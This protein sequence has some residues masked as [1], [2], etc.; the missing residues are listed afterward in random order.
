VVQPTDRDRPV[1]AYFTD[2]EP[3]AVNLRLLFKKIRVPVEKQ[4]Y[5]FTFTGSDGLSQLFN[6]TGRDKHIFY[7]AVDYLVSRE[8]QVYG[9]LTSK[10]NERQI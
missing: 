3:S 10:A 4:E 5:V 9:N 2:L 7:S 8:R 1:G 6:G